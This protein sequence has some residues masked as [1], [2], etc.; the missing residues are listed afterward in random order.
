MIEVE[1]D[2]NARGPDGCVIVPR[3]DPAPT[4]GDIVRVRDADGEGVVTA[5]VREVRD[6]A[7][8]LD[9]DW[10]TYEDSPQHTGIAF[11][12]HAR[13]VIDMTPVRQEDERPYVRIQHGVTIKIGS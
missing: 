4:V 12:R 9:V 11:R 3:L 6:A 7:I 2:L 5:R 13:N 8:L 10:A 1:G